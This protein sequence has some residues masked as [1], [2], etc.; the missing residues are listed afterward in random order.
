[1]A[2]ISVRLLEFS[3]CWIKLFVLTLSPVNSST[4]SPQQTRPR[5]SDLEGVLIRTDDSP[6]LKTQTLSYGDEKD[7]TGPLLYSINLS[8]TDVVTMFRSSPWAVAE[9]VLVPA[10]EV[11]RHDDGTS[12][13]GEVT[14]LLTSQRLV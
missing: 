3:H 12:Q 14:V 11:T 2:S 6:Y 7:F 13:P 5:H 8:K 1:M 9:S 4:F 10:T